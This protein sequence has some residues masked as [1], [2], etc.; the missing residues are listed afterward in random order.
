MGRFDLPAAR[1]WFEAG[2]CILLA[3]CLPAALVRWAGTS[4]NHPERAA[5]RD[6][7]LLL[8]IALVACVGAMARDHLQPATPAFYALSAAL[9]PF[10]IAALVLT[11]R[12]FAAYRGHIRYTP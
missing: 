7:I 3:L 1:T 12:L 2:F 11:V 5:R 9:A 4:R 6:V 10:A 8:A